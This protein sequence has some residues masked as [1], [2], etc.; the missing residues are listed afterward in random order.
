MELQLLVLLIVLGVCT[1]SKSATDQPLNISLVVSNTPTL[2]TTE[3]VPAVNQTLELVHR[4]A[5]LPGYYLQ[6][7]QVLDVQVS[8]KIV[9]VV[10]IELQLDNL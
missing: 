7:S 4:N 8:N 9:A 5:I 3:I 6:Y 10:C 1:P 2:N